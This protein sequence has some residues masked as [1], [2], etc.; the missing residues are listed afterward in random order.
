MELSRE[1][2]LVTNARRKA[3]FLG[4]EIQRIS[5]VKGEIKSYTNKKGHAQRIPTTTLRLNV[6]IKDI[7]SKLITKGLVH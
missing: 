4:V 5:S 3:R 6:P 2:T 7:I 1:K